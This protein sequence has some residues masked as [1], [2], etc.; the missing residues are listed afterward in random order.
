MEPKAISF[1]DSTITTTSQNSSS[2]ETL[3]NPDI[4]QEAKGRK[5]SFSNNV[6]TVAKETIPT[7]LPDPTLSPDPIAKAPVEAKHVRSNSTSMVRRASK[8]FSS[9]INS[10][11]KASEAKPKNIAAEK[12]EKASEAKPTNAQ[13]DPRKKKIEDSL[14][15]LEFV[16]SVEK[17]AAGLINDIGIFKSDYKETAAIYSSVAESCKKAMGNIE[18]KNSPLIDKLKTHLKALDKAVAT[19]DKEAIKI[20]AK[21]AIE[22]N[23]VALTDKK[24]EATL[25]RR[26]IKVHL[27]NL[28][29]KVKDEI[30][31]LLVAPKMEPDTE[32]IEKHN[33]KTLIALSKECIK[34]SK[35]EAISP[36]ARNEL[37]MNAHSLG[38][39][40]A[41]V[42]ISEG[43]IE[44]AFKVRSEL[45][46]KLGPPA[47]NNQVNKAL[48]NK[49][50]SLSGTFVHDMSSK[51]V[52]GGNINIDHR[53]IRTDGKD[54]DVIAMNMA[55][56]YHVRQNIDNSINAD[57]QVMIDAMEKAFPELKGKITIDT[58]SHFSFQKIID[59]KNKIFDEKEGS[60]IGKTWTLKI[61]GVGKLSIPILPKFELNGKTSQ[62][63]VPL[64]NYVDPDG[65]Y[66]VENPNMQVAT[67][68]T[69]GYS[70]S[71]TTIM[72]DLRLEMDEEIGTQNQMKYSQ[73]MLAMVGAGPVFEKDGTDDTACLKSL[74]AFH[75]YFPSEALKLKLNESTSNFTYAELT[76]KIDEVIAGMDKK[77]EVEWQDRIDSRLKI[78]SENNVAINSYKND[79][80]ITGESE[81]NKKLA[82]ALDSAA[83]SRPLYEAL[84]EN[85][86]GIIDDVIKRMDNYWKSDIKYFTENKVGA[87]RNQKLAVKGYREALNGDVTKEFTTVDGRKLYTATN[88]AE[89]IKEA[90]KAAGNPIYG[91][92]AGVGGHSFE[93][94]RK[95]LKVLDESHVTDA[96]RMMKGG[97]K[98]TLTRLNEGVI[99]AKDS[100]PDADNG[101]GAAN[102]IFMR[103]DGKFSDG[104]PVNGARLGGV[105]QFVI[106][107]KALDKH[108]DSA[109]HKT[110]AFGANDPTNI[111][112]CVRNKEGV[113]QNDVLLQESP[114]SF[115]ATL[116]PRD[117]EDCE[118]AADKILD[119]QEF[120]AMTFMTQANLDFMKR[121]LLADPDLFDKDQ[122]W[123][124]IH[125]DN[126][127]IL[128]DAAGF[129][130]EYHK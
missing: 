56:N 48:T 58:D 99:L 5:I 119:P 43:K 75:A 78:I 25:E 77:L 16:K 114:V 97:M 39:K 46:V 10:G 92:Y 27:N 80:L 36:A 52:K 118:I 93:E 13:I 112:K 21:A 123:N 130:Q 31:G 6:S 110:D 85:K 61:D 120:E 2:V 103:P 90:C 66:T 101:N 11:E 17:Q 86:P 42:L 62:R 23:T 100:S 18:D 50:S 124:G 60:K 49:T 70:P 20:N 129:K 128:G 45:M 55:I 41:R 115:F 34:E 117:F 59:Y 1:V 102:K 24:N 54:K 126:F 105:F 109:F 28:K 69:L 4:S 65:K 111:T 57:K 96:I 95:T 82:N 104:K 106:G 19:I 74:E 12:D 40:G 32:K 7:N 76:K 15:K 79:V 121:G 8:I 63:G 51:T 14:K 33:A 29:P 68:Q 113:L 83:L 53:T 37:R 87:L 73:M 89:I 125:I 35:N 127:L 67:G 47:F 91:L 81:A 44:E 3:Q 94:D 38:E 72:H 30:T 108:I 122:R 88:R 64:G 22:L 107:L 26:E 98:S 116:N 71:N 84:I 9:N